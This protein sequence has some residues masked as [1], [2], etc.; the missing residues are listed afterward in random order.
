MVLLSNVGG[1]AP[2]DYPLSVV[3]GSPNVVGTP[4]QPGG[5][6]TL[7]GMPSVARLGSGTARWVPF[8]C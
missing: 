3:L 1:G 2:N 5:R 8:S 6:M 7:A 4:I